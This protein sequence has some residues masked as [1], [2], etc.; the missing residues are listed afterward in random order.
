MGR[1]TPRTPRRARPR[2]LRVADTLR[3]ATR[4]S[5]R[6]SFFVTSSCAATGA[7]PSS[8]LDQRPGHRARCRRNSSRGWSRRRRRPARSTSRWR[9]AAATRVMWSKWGGSVRT[10]SRACGT[11]DCARGGASRSATA[12]IPSSTLRRS[13]CSSAAWRA[14]TGPLV[15]SS[16]RRT[17]PRRRACSRARR[18]PSA[19]PCTSGRGTDRSLRWPLMSCTAGVVAT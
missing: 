13:G 5:W 17:P 18:P 12:R 7:L 11:R 14:C 1:P 6:S 10:S 9:C 8:S 4:R 15:R 16:S 19:R 2:L 3:A